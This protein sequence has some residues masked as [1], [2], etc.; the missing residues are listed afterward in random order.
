[1]GDWTFHCHRSH[2]TITTMGQV[3]PIMVGVDPRGVTQRVVKRVP[4][5]MVAGRGR[6]GRDVDAGPDDAL[7]M[8]TGAGPIEMGGM[9]TVV[10]VRD[11]RIAND[12]RDPGWYKQPPGSVEYGWP[13]AHHRRWHARDTR[14][15]AQTRRSAAAGVNISDQGTEGR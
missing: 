6:Q 10:M 9:F 15:D 12:D 4:D 8:M 7:P 13:H 5:S 1:M 3:E 11:D 14:A 2:Q